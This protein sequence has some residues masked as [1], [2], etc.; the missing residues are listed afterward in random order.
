VIIPGPI[1]VKSEPEK[2]F[3]AFLVTLIF[4][5]CVVLFL[6]VYVIYRNYCQR[7]KSSEKNIKMNGLSPNKTGK[8]DLA[9]EKKKSSPLG[10][11]H[12]EM[13]E[14]ENEKL[15]QKSDTTPPLPAAA[16]AVTTTTN[17]G[18][19]QPPEDDEK[20]SLVVGT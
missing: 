9:N 7:G 16:A 8:Y 12:L 13:S 17:G 11:V 20:D 3:M 5:L 10:E 1:P 18:A 4:L 15:I 6:L 14:N 19:K 2:Y